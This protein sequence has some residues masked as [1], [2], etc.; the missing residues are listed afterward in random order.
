MSRRRC[1][2]DTTL[3]S[4]TTRRQFEPRPPSFEMDSNVSSLRNSETIAALETLSASTTSRHILS[5]QPDANPQDKSKT[6]SSNRAKSNTCQSEPQIAKTKLASDSRCK[7]SETS[8]G[9]HDSLVSEFTDHASPSNVNNDG[10]ISPMSHKTLASPKKSQTMADHTTDSQQNHTK[11]GISSRKQAQKPKLRTISRNSKTS[12]VDSRVKVVKGKDDSVATAKTSTATPPESKTKPSSNRTR[13]VSSLFQA[14]QRQSRIQ[15]NRSTSK[16]HSIDSQSATPPK[17]TETCDPT[18]KQTPSKI[19]ISDCDLFTSSS[20]TAKLPSASVKMSSK[21]VP[22]THTISKQ[23]PSAPADRK[24]KALHEKSSGGSNS[25][26]PPASKKVKI[27]L[28]ITPPSTGRTII[29][30][31]KFS[32]PRKSSPISPTPISPTPISLH[33]RKRS[34][35]SGSKKV[36]AHQYISPY[37][38]QDS[39]NKP[40]R[41]RLSPAPLK[42]TLIP[43]KKVVK[44]VAAAKGKVVAGKLEGDAKECN[45]EEPERKLTGEMLDR[46]QIMHTKPKTRSRVIR[47][48]AK[49]K[50]PYQFIHPYDGKTTKTHRPYIPNVLPVP[51][52]LLKECTFDNLIEQC[53]P[54]VLGISNVQNSLPDW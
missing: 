15:V 30:T 24:R 9:D 17:S 5:R 21:A 50:E 47:S 25:N 40:I 43:N 53:G 52:T 42:K 2:E 19:S 54:L 11:A 16:N 23:P 51:E 34:N 46:W 36:E 14:R 12:V 35:E 28:K 20:S 31:S 38:V 26:I 41:I 10:L 22:L 44:N 27:I 8:C 13:A 4:P 48:H 49:D 45:A 37:P 18:V 7:I 29:D 3:I 6:R 39:P 32:S 1:R 33:E